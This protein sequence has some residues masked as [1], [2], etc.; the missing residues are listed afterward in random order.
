M[1]PMTTGPYTCNDGGNGDSRS[2]T[3]DL[4]VKTHKKE[5]L[6]YYTRKLNDSGPVHG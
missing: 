5:K 1:E 3:R 4:G 6:I 2:Y